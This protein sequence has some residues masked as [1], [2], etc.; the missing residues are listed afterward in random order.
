MSFV[1]CVAKT[2]NGEYNPKYKD[3]KE[4][5]LYEVEKK[6][7]KKPKHDIGSADDGNI[8]IYQ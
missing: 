7:K 3:K 5:Q 4:V 8:S 1:K 2:K 6:G